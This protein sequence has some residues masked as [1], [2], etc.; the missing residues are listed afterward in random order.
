[1]SRIPLGL[2]VADPG[3]LAY[4]QR[5]F[6]D[7]SV[8]VVQSVEDIR[9]LAEGAAV[10]IDL[11][12]SGLSLRD[13]LVWAAAARHARLVFASTHPCDPEGL[14]AMRLG[15]VGYCHAYAAPATLAQVLSVVEAGGLWVGE[16]LLGRLLGGVGRAL[17]SAGVGPA[18]SVLALLSER[19]REV[20]RAASMGATNKVI[21]RDLQI[22]ERT[23]KAHLTSI[24]QKLEVEDRLQLSLKLN[25]IS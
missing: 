10:L 22:T 6:P 4:W 3:L 21:A 25:G 9:R 20:A 2:L 7:R 17:Q 23:V 18:E 5:S 11:G 19:E 15:G 13:E 14:E 8:C 1:M 12:M 16:S 24:F